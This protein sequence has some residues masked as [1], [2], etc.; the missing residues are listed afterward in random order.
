MAM[1]ARRGLLAL[2]PH[3]RPG[4][5][6]ED[7]L[8]DMEIPCHSDP[9]GWFPNSSDTDVKETARSMCRYRCPARLACLKAALD[10]QP[11][12]SIWGG[13]Y[14]TGHWYRDEAKIR[15]AIE[16]LEGGKA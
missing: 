10:L 14:M 7:P 15:R 8:R 1:Q 16:Y 13:I 11:P 2:I 6:S 9:E 5:T 3:D 12:H 4:L